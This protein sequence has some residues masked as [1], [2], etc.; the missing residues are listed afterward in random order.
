MAVSEVLVEGIIL[1]FLI[2]TPAS[3]DFTPMEIDVE[4]VSDSLDDTDPFEVIQ[5]VIE[6][7]RDV[8]VL[9]QE[10]QVL[11]EVNDMSL[12]ESRA[13]LTTTI[14]GATDQ[15]REL[16]AIIHDEGNRCIISTNTWQSAFSFCQ[17]DA[18][19]V[20]SH[21]DELHQPART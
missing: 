4:E 10:G 2:K 7:N 14:D 3:N 17:N 1:Q 16:H 9:N 12:E 8:L 18:R 21:Q 19:S 11:Y 5:H 6:E 20:V 13:R 15:R